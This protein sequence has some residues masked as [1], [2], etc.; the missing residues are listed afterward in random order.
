MRQSLV[1]GNWKM[2][3]R[4]TSGL[5]L[6]RDMV[7]KAAA[8]KP[9]GFDLVLCPPA[10]LIWPVSEIIAGTPVLLGGQD[11]HYATHGAYTGDISAAQLADLNQNIQNKQLIAEVNLYESAAERMGR[12]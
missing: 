9:L 8:N 4:L 5:T 1:I 6:A 3:G 10:T 11:C 12:E 2:N 7:E